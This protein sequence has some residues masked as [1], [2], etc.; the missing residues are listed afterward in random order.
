MKRLMK[1]LS[2]FLILFFVAAPAWAASTP[3]APAPEVSIKD[4]APGNGEEAVPYSTVQV[5]YTGWTVDGKKFDSSLD[6]GTPFDFTLSAGQVIPGWDDGVE[7]MRVGG[8][9]ELVIP[10][11]LAYGEQ[12]VPGVIPANATLKFEVELLGVTPPAFANIDNAQLKEL[13]ARGVP[14]VDLRREEEWKQTGV[15]EGSKLITAIDAKGKFLPPFI[16][17]FKAVAGPDDEVILICRTGNRTAAVSNYLSRAE[18]YKKIYN[19]RH[20]ITRWIKE[21]GPVVKP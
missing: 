11:E 3:P 7:G 13:L 20:G 15:V 16:E 6:R 12:G 8:K 21:D 2:Q 17:G 19:V 9:R 5:H 4:L 10:P 14:I 1:C 18:G